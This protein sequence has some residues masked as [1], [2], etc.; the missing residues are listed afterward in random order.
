MSSFNK[1]K[2]IYIIIILIIISWFIF[3]PSVVKLPKVIVKKDTIVT[4]VLPPPP[5][6]PPTILIPP[7]PKEEEMI[8]QEHVEKV[9]PDVPIESKDESIT[10]NIPNGVDM[11]ISNGNGNGNTNKIGYNSHRGK[12]D[13]YAISIQK[14]ITES[15][16]Q[17][18]NI[19][20][21]KFNIQL[22]IWADTTGRITRILLMK[23]TGDAGVDNIIKNNSLVGLQ[24]SEQPPIG[25][26]MP[27][28]IHITAT[29]P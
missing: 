1:W 13:S 8:S 22:R 9:E 14:T 19:N 25:L 10:T 3:K 24:L 15:L 17:N 21:S 28:T 6:P 26:P 27:I 18:S 2:S 7:P 23:S 20:H 4:I 16:R 29:I 11:G 5:P 12:W